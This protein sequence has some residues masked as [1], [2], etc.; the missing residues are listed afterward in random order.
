MRKEQH[1]FKNYNKD[2][3]KAQGHKTF[4]YQEAHNILATR[5][6]VIDGGQGDDVPWQLLG[7]PLAEKGALF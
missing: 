6:G 3:S 2:S 1:G 5:S 7:A 4:L